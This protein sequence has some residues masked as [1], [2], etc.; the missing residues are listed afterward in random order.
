MKAVPIPVCRLL[1]LLCLFPGG[2][3]PLLA[4]ADATLPNADFNEGKTSPAGWVPE[5][6][7]RWVDHSILEV[8][9]SGS[10]SSRWKSVPVPLRPGGVYRFRAHVRRVRGSGIATMGADFANSDLSGLKTSWEWRESV[11]REASPIPRK[12]TFHLGQWH[13]KGAIQFDG[14]RLNRVVPIYLAT[15]NGAL[16][17]GESILDGTYRFSGSFSRLGGNDHRPLK[18]ATAGFN[19]NRWVFGPGSCATY[20]FQVPGHAFLSGHVLLNLC[21]CANDGLCRVETSRDGRTWFPLATTGKLGELAADVPPGQFP[22]KA[23]WLRVRADGDSTLFQVDRIG[24]EG[25]LEGNPAAA[26]GETRYADVVAEGAP[27]RVER[28]FLERPPGTGQ[29]LLVAEVRNTGRTDAVLSVTLDDPLLPK[30]VLRKRSVPA[31]GIVRF[32]LPLKA[33][34]AGRRKVSLAVSAP[35]GAPERVAF[36]CSVPEL[37]RTDYGWRLP[38]GQGGQVGLWWCRADRKVPRKRPLP[39]AAA[40]AVRIDAA[41]NDV[42]D[43]QIVVAPTR[44]LRGLTATVSRLSGPGGA[45]IP[46][47]AVRILRAYYHFVSHPTDSIGLWGWWPDALPPLDAPL[48]VPAGENQPIWVQVHVPAT[49]PPG[50]YAGTVSLKAEGF[51][52]SI[53]ITLHVWNFALPERNHLETAFG[54]NVGTIFRYQN[55]K[56]EADKR[57]VLDLYFQSFAEH[58]ISPYNPTPMD[59]IRTRFRTDETPPRVEM[60]FAAFDAA[61]ERALRKWNFT[62][63]RLPIQGMGG[64][65][66]HKRYPP[67]IGP[68]TEG[69]SA[70]QMLFSNYVGRIEGHLREKGWLDLAYVYWFD[71]PAPRDYP[72]V[73]AGM[74]RLKHC[75]PGLRRM[76]TEQPGDNAL[77]GLVDI[78]CPVSYNYDGKAAAACRA[79]GEKFWWYVCTE[80]K[81]PYCGLFID[82]PATELR[83]WLWQTWKRGIVGTLVWQANYW[84]S[85]T[86]F[87][88]RPQNPYEDPMGY[89]T[90]YGTP[91]GTRRFWGNGDGRFIYPPLA[92]AEPGRNGGRPVVAPPV[93]SI[94]WEMLRE[95]IEDYEFL[96]LL[97]ER[98]ERRGKRLPSQ[99]RK[100]FEALLDVPPEISADMTDFTTDPT[101][102][103]TRRRAIAE[104]IEAL[105]E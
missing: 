90:G 17:E 27:A 98:L 101:P 32:A 77:A 54:L 95:G 99:T 14:V 34:S 43:A 83:V 35:G 10:D 22:A 103:Y 26:S 71:E 81:A 28:F 7:G 5:G 9:G 20:R 67:K 49:A 70:Y 30:P 31:G 6:G 76:L 36:E 60:D 75:A 24:F 42:E 89:V 59:P 88:D 46:K 19:S 96:Y 65:T 97:R 79:R 50:D 82:H 57:R 74:R 45:T 8:D 44:P 91:K 13:A 105:G 87:P 15:D 52:A 29:D 61:M 86:A 55:L 78:W 18:E 72:F 64:G 3:P 23:L 100:R 25:R 69:T 48:D 62:G 16:G 39:R 94:R 92:A 93:T 84:T 73:A 85:Q 53:P 38:D 63:F 47:D 21:Y 4:A 56:T 80:P 12:S 68:F 51:S 1:A 41:R 40:T 37:R 2:V 33:G 11:F 102:I 104:A 58:R 66:Y